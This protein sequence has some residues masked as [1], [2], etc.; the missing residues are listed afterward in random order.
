VVEELGLGRKVDEEEE[1]EGRRG[2]DLLA[3][4]RDLEVCLLDQEGE[5]QLVDFEEMGGSRC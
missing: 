3:C 2:D 5:E 4:P 1:E